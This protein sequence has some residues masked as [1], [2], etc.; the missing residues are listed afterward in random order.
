MYIG[1][2]TVRF[3]HAHKNLVT[4]ISAKYGVG[5]QFRNRQPAKC[6]SGTCIREVG[7]YLCLS[8]LFEC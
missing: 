5:M 8:Y 7:L 6:Q 3:L 2:S 1:I 4:I